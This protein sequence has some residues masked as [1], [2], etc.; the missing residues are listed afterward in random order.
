MRMRR[1]LSVW[2]ILTLML[3]QTSVFAAPES[4]LTALGKTSLLEKI[5]F[6]TEQTGPFVERV[7]KLEKDI[8]GNETKA[9]LLDKVDTLYNYTKVS[10]TATPSFLLKLNSAEWLFN[11][12]ISTMPAQ[13]RLETLEKNLLGSTSSGALDAR[14]GRLMQVAFTSGQLN[15]SSVSVP[16]DTLIKIRTLSKIDS[17]K[18]RV[19][20]FVAFKVIDDVYINGYLAIPAG[21]QGRGR[22]S[23]VQQ[24]ANFGRDAKVEIAFDSVEALDGTIVKT[25]IGDKAKEQT[26][27]LALAAGA[28]VAGLAILGPIGI[29]GGA[30]VHGQEVV[31]PTGTDMFIQTA[32]A[33]ELYGVQ[34]K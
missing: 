16:K 7:A 32:G 29:V 3:A 15:T 30:F 19:G 25:L 6:G 10:S 33:T 11:H 13:S 9:S 14:L 2:L 34:M 17:A 8:L 24:K 23:Q 22:I 26:R 4:D 28:S 5:Y 12:S 31:I 27:S 20:D 1:I 18:S 21:T